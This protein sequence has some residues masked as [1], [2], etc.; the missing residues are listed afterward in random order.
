MAVTTMAKTSSLKN[1]LVADFP[2]VHFVES[3]DFYWSPSTKTVHYGTIS[4]VQD[5]LTLLHEAAHAVLDHR[6]FNRDIELLKIEREAWDYVSEVLAPQYGLTVDT[7]AIE[8]MID[9][10]REWL[11]ARS[12]CPRC[13]LTGIQT[14]TSLYHCLGCAQDWRVNEARR[15]GLKRYS[16]TT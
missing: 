12:Q 9:T 16:I 8:D 1:K 15:C 7:A 5:E 3:D 11:H 10:Y 13:S 14:D 6:Q 2:T 4:S